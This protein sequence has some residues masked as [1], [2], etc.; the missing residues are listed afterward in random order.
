M[1]EL[2]LKEEKVLTLKDIEGV[3][4]EVAKIHA[5]ELLPLC[6]DS[7]C[8]TKQ[9]M[10][11]LHDRSI[12]SNREGIDQVKATF[13]EKWQINKNFASLSDH[14]WI[15]KRSETYRK[16]NFFTNTYSKDIGNMFFK[17][18]AVNRTR[19][20]N[21]S[22]DLTTGG[23]LTK[24][25]RQN[26]DKSSCLIKAGSVA[27]Q[28]EPL[29]EVLV[30]VLAEQLGTIKCADYNLHI[31]GTT[32]CS[33]C[34]NFVTMD[35]DLV[36]ASYIYYKE[37]KQAGESVFSHLVRMCERYDI[38]GAE[39]FL[40]WMVFIDRITGNTDRNLNNIGFLR[41]IKT[42]KFI[43]PA[44]LFDS[45]NAYWSTKD[46]NNAVKSNL[47][48]DI[49]NGI[50]KELNKNSNIDNILHETGYKRLIDAY[51]CISELK[52]GNLIQAISKRNNA[53]LKEQDLDSPEL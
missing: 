34:S 21:F 26:Q 5:P 36:P 52:K 7:D 49:E 50:F 46:I 9:F 22:P 27:A 31:E 29:S 43:G 37:E 32:M 4:S 8:D 38:P 16:I 12:P 28:Q 33:I 18:W 10:K 40:K 2:C 17:P 42:M 48:G 39:D 6:L 20:D 53:L 30:A 44:P 47:F 45:G 11:W 3:P 15:K 35:T 41:D 25:W 13:G 14:Y 23:I 1:S 19:Y 51:P 24:C